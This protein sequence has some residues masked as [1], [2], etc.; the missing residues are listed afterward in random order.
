M[1]QEKSQTDKQS[2]SWRDNLLDDKNF[3]QKILYDID[4]VI[5]HFQNLTLDLDHINPFDL[6]SAIYEFTKAFSKFSSALSMGFSDITEKV[7]TWRDLFKLHSEEEIKD[8]QSLMEK[9]IKNGLQ[10]LNGDNNSSLG[11]KKGTQYYTYVSGCRTMVRLSWFLNFLYKTF[12]NMLNTTDPFSSCIKNAYNEVLA[13]HHPWLVRNSVSLIL[14]MAG[15]KRE[16]ALDA[17]FCKFLLIQ[18]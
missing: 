4:K 1:E 16:P 2:F 10:S 13:P 17:F 7:Q 12:K 14:N 8:I 11:H 3:D 9:E 5:K 15:S 6:F 18:R